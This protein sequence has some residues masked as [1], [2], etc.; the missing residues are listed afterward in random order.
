MQ[1]GEK[2]STAVAFKPPLA[3]ASDPIPRLLEMK[4]I[5]LEQL[6]IIQAPRITSFEFPSSARAYFSPLMFATYQI[7]RYYPAISLELLALQM[8]GPTYLNWLVQLSTI[9]SAFLTLHV[10]V[11]CTRHRTGFVVGVSCPVFLAIFF[12]S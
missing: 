11:L 6:G 5:A 3:A 9:V 10:L 8:L 7:S 2:Q 12:Y 4:A 1:S